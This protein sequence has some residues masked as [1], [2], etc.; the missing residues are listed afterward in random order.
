MKRV[1]TAKQISCPEC[2]HLVT[3]V[4]CVEKKLGR[5]YRYRRCESC[6]HKFKTSQSMS[7]KNA[8]ETIVPYLELVQIRQQRLLRGGGR[9]KLTPDDVRTIRV[10]WIKAVYKDKQEMI[11]IAEQFKVK[12]RAVKNIL[13]GKAWSFVA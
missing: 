9:S 3:K 8:K 1:R 11:H 7:E 13:T 6:D 10:M 4:T 5:R 12:E 2:D